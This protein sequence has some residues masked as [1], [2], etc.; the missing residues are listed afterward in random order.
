MAVGDIVGTKVARLQDSNFKTVDSGSH[1]TSLNL[2][3]EI[4]RNLGLVNGTRIKVVVYKNDFIKCLCG[5]MTSDVRLYYGRTIHKSTN[6]WFYDQLDVIGKFFGDKDTKEYSMN[7]IL[8]TDGRNYFNDLNSEGFNVREYLVQ[9]HTKITFVSNTAGFDMRLSMGR[10]P[11]E[12]TDDEKSATAA[13]EREIRFRAYLESADISAR[14]LYNYVTC[15]KSK[16][17][18]Q[19]V[20]DVT[21]LILSSLYECTDIDL[22]EKIMAS[23]PFKSLNAKHHNAFS[24]AINKYISFLRLPEP[25]GSKPEEPEDPRRNVIYY[26]APGTGKSHTVNQITLGKSHTRIT[27]HPDT[28]HAAFVGSYKPIKGDDGRIS[29][30]YVPQAF[31]KAYV[32][33]WNNPERLHYLIIEEINRGSCAQIF[34][35]IFQLLDRDEEGFSKYPIDVDTDLARYISENIENPDYIDFVGDYN[36]IVLPDNLYIYATMN[37]SDQS[38]FPMD[39]AFKRR[40]DWMYVPINMEDASEFTI[41]LDDGTLYEWGVFLKEIN[42]RI[43]ELTAS[44]DKQIGNRFVTTAADKIIPPDQFRSKVMFYLWTE[45]YK[46]EAKTTNTIFVRDTEGKQ[47]FSYGDLF[48]A[49]SVQIMKDFMA[50]LSVPVKPATTE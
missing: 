23:E 11:F 15:L 8:R 36:K 37:T 24:A 49:E 4:A 43:R 25:A 26:G 31:V 34:G 41:R 42:S 1:E 44:E 12:K 10:V 28:D 38:L 17:L 47:E 5:I 39:S 2:S 30:E 33:A 21:G 46:D 32:A 14:T 18:L 50:V 45:L 13:L 48:G 27:F 20:A 19:V 6:K 16:L 35:D 40:W 3:N 22:I 29:Y 9:D 7:V